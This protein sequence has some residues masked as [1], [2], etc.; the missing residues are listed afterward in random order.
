MC[1]SG[2]SFL[3]TTLLKYA[4]ADARLLSGELAVL[5]SVLKSR[6]VEGISRRIHDSSPFSVPM[7][8]G[9]GGKRNFP[10]FHE[11]RVCDRLQENRKSKNGETG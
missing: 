2:P 3:A 6:Q 1:R 5:K 8:R 7:G 9:R 11:K 10:H 4:P